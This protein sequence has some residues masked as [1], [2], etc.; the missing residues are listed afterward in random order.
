[1]AQPCSIDGVDP[2]L[3]VSLIRIGGEQGFRRRLMEM[4]FVPGTHIQVRHRSNSGDL[5]TL[6]VRGSCIS[7]RQNEAQ[8]LFVQPC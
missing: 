4:G 7:I 8:H 6:E 2:G 3:D 1:M 5:L